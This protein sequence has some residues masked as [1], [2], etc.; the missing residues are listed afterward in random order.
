MEQ[1]RAIIKLTVIMLIT[2]TRSMS[3]TLRPKMVSAVR[4]GIAKLTAT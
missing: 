4:T 2:T 1:L 3:R